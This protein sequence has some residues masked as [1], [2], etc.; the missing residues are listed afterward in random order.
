MPQKY[1]DKRTAK[2]TAGERVKEFQSFEC[3]SDAL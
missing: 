2:F 3:Q 1:K